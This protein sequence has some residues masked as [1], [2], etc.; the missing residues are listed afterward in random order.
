MW[1][2]LTSAHLVPLA[3]NCS[4]VCLMRCHLLPVDPSA[5]LVA[6]GAQDPSIQVKKS[7]H[8]SKDAEGWKH[9]SED[10]GSERW[11]WRCARICFGTHGWFLF[12]EQWAVLLRSSNVRYFCCHVR[13]FSHPKKIMISKIYMSC[14]TS[15]NWFC[16]E[17]IIGSY[18]CDGPSHEC[19][20]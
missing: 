13:R 1:S 15:V 6:A 4:F 18:G 10:S 2:Q 3:M 17:S 16:R 9:T 19:E 7:R 14:K 12:Q 5:C 8:A 11:Q 20:V